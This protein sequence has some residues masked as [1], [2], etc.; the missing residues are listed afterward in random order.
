MSG[1]FGAL[2]LQK[3]S[4]DVYRA[5]SSVDL[6]SHRGPDD[7]GYLFFHTGARH[8]SEISFYQNLTDDVFR[9]DLL[10]SIDNEGVQALLAS[11]D[12]DLFLAHRRLSILDLSANAHQPM[13]ELSKNIWLSLDGTIYNFKD[14]RQELERFGYKFQ[15]KSCEEVVIY[16]YAQ[17]GIECIK[18]FNG[19]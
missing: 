7:A 5:R 15:T 18:R 2:G 11:H 12:W 13:S 19:M 8:N 9:S 3:V 4:V 10:A 6:L 14:L 17:W 16:A 1:I